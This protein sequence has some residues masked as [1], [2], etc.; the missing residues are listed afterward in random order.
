MSITFSKMEKAARLRS[1]WCVG[2]IRMDGKFG[3]CSVGDDGVTIW[4]PSGLNVNKDSQRQ[5]ESSHES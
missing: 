3:S 2:K 1:G 4:S 5:T